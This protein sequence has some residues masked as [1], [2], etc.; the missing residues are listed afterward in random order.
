MSNPMLNENKFTE[1]MVLEGEPMTI[2]GA[3]GKIFLLFVC[4]LAGCGV[5]LHYLNINPSVATNMMGVAAILGFICVLISAFNISAAKYLAAPYALFEGIFLGTVSAFFE[6]MYPGIVLHAIGGTFAVLGI[7]LFLYKAKVITYTQQLQAVIKTGVLSVFAIY[8]IEFIASFFGRGIPLIFE[9]GPIGIL[10][11]IGVII[12]AAVTLVQ[13]FF[14]I[15]TYSQ[16]MLSKDYEWYSAMG[17]MVTLVWLYMEIL[18]LLAKLNSR[19]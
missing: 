14:L 1:T 19:N 8:L 2:Q 9:A 12:L 4:L 18:R 3:V 10:F 16:R 15:E 5:S 11:S 17:L 6:K 7:M 13:D